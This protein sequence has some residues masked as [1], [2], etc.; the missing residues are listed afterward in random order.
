MSTRPGIGAIVTRGG[1][2]SSV[3]L[4]GGSAAI[5]RH[6]VVVGSGFSRGEPMPELPPQRQ[7]GGDSGLK[8]NRMLGVMGPYRQLKNQGASRLPDNEGQE[9]LTLLKPPGRGAAAAAMSMH[10]GRRP[11]QKRGPIVGGTILDTNI[12]QI[13]AVRNMDQLKAQ[14]SK[15]SFRPRKGQGQGQGESKKIRTWF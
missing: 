13:P 3:G 11:I 15:V 1:M 5:P 12:P 7:A 6:R 14:L 2:R 10:G 9:V 4:F 8:T